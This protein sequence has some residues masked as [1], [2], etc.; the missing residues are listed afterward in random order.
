M[1]LDP[2]TGVRKSV[3]SG[4]TDTAVS[5]SSSLDGRLLLSRSFGG[6]VKL[7]DVQTGGVI[8]TFDHHTSAISASISPDGT[9]I[10]LGTSK[11]WGVILL[12]DVQTWRRRSIEMGQD[13]TVK[14]VKFS[15]VDS[16][17]LLSS[18]Q[19]GTVSQWSVDGHQIGTSYHEERGVWDLAYALDGTRFVSCGGR[20]ATVRDSATGEVVV[21]LNAPDKNALSNCCLSLDGRLVACRADTIIYVWDITI[22]GPRLVGHIE[23]SR[24]VTSIAFPSSLIS[25][26]GDRSVKFWPSNGFLLDSV[27]TDHMAMLRGST[28][29]KSINL[30]AEEGAVVTSDSSGVVKTWDLTTGRLK[31]SFLTLAKGSRRDTR[32]TGNTLTIVW[33]TEGGEY[34]IWDVYKGQLLRGFHSALS[35]PWDFKISGD[36]S[37]IFALS[38]ACIQAMSMQTG[39]ETGRV[40][41][42]GGEGPNLF[43]RGSKV[44]INNQYDRGW[45]FGGPAVSD[46]G[47]LPDRPRFDLVNW[48]TSYT[49]RPCWIEDISTKRRI[50]HLPERYTK[51][52]TK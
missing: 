52:N 14:I 45:D 5:L 25:G 32:L 15:P 41:L 34:C 42:R 50:F 26:S 30:F 1:L 48:P 44:G 31:S 18:S 33:C 35:R 28:S 9:T 7:W 4:H 2:I 27:T 6:T 13:K 22:S 36:G 39:E 20:N 47:E 19:G 40:K 51:N 24:S 46:L 21:K 23:H 3:L 43:V 37:K 12:W 16:Q 49:A 29:I 10:A 38:Y 8:R 17:R 11:A